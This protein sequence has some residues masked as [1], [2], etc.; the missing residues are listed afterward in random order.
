[1]WCRCFTLF[2]PVSPSFADSGNYSKHKLLQTDPFFS[3][4]PVTAAWG[5]VYGIAAVLVPTV[6]SIF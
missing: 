6:G 4:G 3:P 1:M 5:L 2:L